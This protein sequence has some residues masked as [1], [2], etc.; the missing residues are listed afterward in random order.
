MIDCVAVIVLSYAIT[1]SFPNEA[2][3]PER[4]TSSLLGAETVASVMGMQ[5][6][7]IAFMALAFGLVTAD[8]GY[9]PWPAHVAQGSQPLKPAKQTYGAG[10]LQRLWVAT[11]GAQA[12]R[13]TPGRS[14]P[15]R[16]PELRRPAPRP[17]APTSDRRRAL[18]RRSANLAE[19]R[20]RRMERLRASVGT[21][22]PQPEPA[23]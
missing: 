14:H 16:P 3:K 4:P 20:Q 23:T 19:R 1:L 10:R 8:P 21:E 22:Q 13:S 2:L 7:N 6:I 15:A 11:A 18:A 12:E 5:L 17:R 9:V